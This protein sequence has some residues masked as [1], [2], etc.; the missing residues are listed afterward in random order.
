MITF[1]FIKNENIHS[2][3]PLLQVLNEKISEEI[4]K[5]RLN[6]MIKQNY[7]CIGIFDK[8]QLIGICGIWI[9]TKYYVGKHIEPD[10]VIILSE[11]QNQNI[12][13]KLMNWIY[14]Y[15]KKNDCVASELN[16]Y[17]NNDKAHKFWEKEGYKVIG[18]HYQKKFED[19]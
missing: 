9:L 5:S 19:T 10:N 15:A 14:D 16:C 4:L 7:Q 1:R 3:I 13:K 2:I 11:Y 6:E 17:V 8:K 12:G 18:L